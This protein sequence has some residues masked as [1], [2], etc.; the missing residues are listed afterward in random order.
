VSV[1]PALTAASG[2]LA[3]RNALI[4]GASRG[5]GAAV[6]KRYA[7]EGAH[8][9]LVART[10]GGLE[11]VDD[12]IRSAGGA[13]TLVPLDLVEGAKIDELGARLFERFGRLDI[14][15]GSAATLGVLTPL[16]HMDPP[17]WERV[18][19]V[20]LTANWRLL[21]GMDPLLR[22]SGTGRA[23]FVTSGAARAAGPYWGAYAASKAALETMIR[24]YAAEAAPFG[25]RA[26]LVDPGAV[27]TALRA[28]AFPGEDA[29]T[30]PA[31]EAITEIFVM[32]GES[33]C[34][35]NGQVL[36]A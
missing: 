4:T 15:V 22:R 27:R 18:L 11:E 3:G 33:D 36:R 34:R 10:V 1:A 8:V 20:N 31:P 23:I 24:T 29:A 30:L 5:I 9:V 21:R 7:A 32:L 16:T 25:V 13:A 17:V 14:L 26:N 6:A 19:A 35:Q 12:A 28:Q 2:R